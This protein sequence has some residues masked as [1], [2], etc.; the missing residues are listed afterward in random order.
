MA[1]TASTGL[2]QFRSFTEIPLVRQMGMIAALAMAIAGGMALFTW[3]QSP[4][5]QPLYS[6]LSQK[7]SADLAD[8]MR[9]ANIPVKIDPNTGAV[10]VPADKLNDARMRAAAA[11]LPKSTAMGFEM[12]QQNESFGTSQFIEAARYQ[13]ALETELARTVAALQ[14]VKSARVHLALPKPS[15]FAQT[16]GTPSASVLVELRPGRMLEDGQVDSIQHMVASS[17]PNLS[18]SNVTVIDQ[19][20]RLLSGGDKNSALA[21]SSQE[22]EYAR[23]AENDYESRIEDILTPMLGPNHVRAQVDADFDFSQTEQATESYDPQKTAVRSEQTSEDTTRAPNAGPNG[24]P[25]ATSN[26]PPA[27]AA[28]PA[29]PAASVQALQGGNT[30]QSTDTTVSQSKSETRNYEVDRTVSHTRQAVGQLKRLSVAVLV[31]NTTKTDADGNVTSVPLT[32]AQLAQVEALVKQAVGFN[33]QRGDTVT[34]QNAAFKAEEIP[35]L[36]P[37]PLWKRP[38]FREYLRQ[39]LGALIVLVL[40]FAVL[41]PTL[42]SLLAGAPRVRHQGAIQGEIADEP[43]QQQ[44]LAADAAGATALA[45][46]PYE[47]KLALARAAVTQDPKRVAQV[48]KTWIG[49]DGG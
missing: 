37:I 10:M 12:I 17:V 13:L 47:Q 30:A 20:G 22:Y 26:Q 4:N 5:Y 16:S 28:P 21:Q 29:K 41:R 38:E 44:A 31:D 19:Y 14:P 27:T 43:A 18:A 1:D 48:M 2:A 3:S 6:D 34:V 11:G 23:R 45:P 24:V 33:P 15:A 9:A 49:E 46:P 40:I 32:P 8:A 7:D 36:T 42:R 25:G 39:G 35:P